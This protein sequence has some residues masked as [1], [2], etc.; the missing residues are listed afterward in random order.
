MF[1]LHDTIMAFVFYS[2]SNLRVS[3]H[4]PFWIQINVNSLIFLY[5]F[6]NKMC[7]HFRISMRS[8]KHPSKLFM[9]FIGFGFSRIT[10]YISYFFTF[11]I[12]YL[13]IASV[14]I[15]LNLKSF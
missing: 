9:A 12:A 15:T 11:Y 4:Y 6:Y 14:V 13:I 7:L 1:G 5:G 8:Y 2:L 10:V 3:C